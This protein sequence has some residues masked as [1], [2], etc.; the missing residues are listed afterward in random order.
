MKY[1]NNNFNY[2]FKIFCSISLESQLSY[3]ISHNDWKNII[4]WVQNL[5]INSL[6]VDVYGILHLEDDKKEWKNLINY[7]NSKIIYLC[8]VCYI[9]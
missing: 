4:E 3:Y 2:F 9:L 7:I 1:I 5:N 8:T 6:S